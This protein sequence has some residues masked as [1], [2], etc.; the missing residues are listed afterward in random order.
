MNPPKGNFIIVAVAIGAGAALATR[1]S[2]RYALGDRGWR[3]RP[4]PGG[5]HGP[6]H[7]SDGFGQRHR[8]RYGLAISSGVLMADDAAVREIEEALRIAERASDDLALGLAR[9]TLGIALVHRD[10]PAERD[11]G[12]KL[13]GQVRDMCLRGGSTCAC[14]RSSTCTRRVSGL[15]AETAMM[16]SR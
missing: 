1:G 6:Q 7:R 9:F 5:R 11:R 3:E 8:L 13:L 16:P 14:L 10:S 2:A 15:G 12:L 4:R